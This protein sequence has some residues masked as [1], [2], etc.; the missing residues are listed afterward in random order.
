MKLATIKDI[1]KKL[2]LNHGTVSRALSNAPHVSS[3][4]R[5]RVLEMAKELN[6]MPNMA[7]KGLARAKSNTV[8]VVTFSYFN[9]FAVDLIKGIET[10]MLKT[11]YDMV[12]YS[13]SQYTFVGTAGRD[14]YIY[15][16]ILNEKIADALI[17]FS[18]ILYGKKDITAR[19]K[20]AGIQLVF[21]EGKDTWGNRVHYNNL[22]AARMAVRHFQE[23]KRKKIGMLIGNTKI[24][25][26]FRERRAG[27]LRSFKPQDRKAAAENIFEFQENTPP[28]MIVRALN[29]F[30]NKKIDAVYAASGEEHSLYLLKEAR[31]M[32][33]RVPEDFAI[34]GQDDSPALEMAD[35]TLIEQPIVEMEGDKVPLRDELFYP[36]LIVRKT[37]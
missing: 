28:E 11:K 22:A 15:E 4:T 14:S 18:G 26:S 36:E 32:G 3:I 19:Y 10:E 13:S 21:I 16:K 25:Q 2:G 37:T 30:V 29:F 6:Y 20:K 34:I 24:V 1:A 31:K 23:K 5:R 27:F 8:A 9:K 12:Y 7:A 33:L 17:V 35:I